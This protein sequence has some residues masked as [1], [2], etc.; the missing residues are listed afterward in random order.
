M[1]KI[2]VLAT[3]GLKPEQL[4]DND[5]KLYPRVDYLELKRFLDIDILNYSLY[6]QTW[7]G[8]SFRSLETQI[9]SDLY[10]TW[11]GWRARKNYDL[12]FTMSERA[13]IP[14]AGFRRLG[15]NS[16]PFVTMFQS[17]SWRQESVIK[18][19]GLLG[20]MDGIAVHCHSMKC[21][22][23]DLGAPL[24]DIQVLPYS[25]DHQF[26]KPMKGVE[27]QQGLIMSV[28]EIRS[29]D[30]GTLMKAV[31]KLPLRLVIAASGSWYAREKTTSLRLPIPDNTTITGRM[32]SFKLRE[33]YAQAQFVVLPVYNTVYSAGSTVV[34]EAS[35]MERAV[36]A[37]RSEGIVDYIIDGETGILVEPNNP[38]ALR[39]AIRYLQDHPG[40]AKRMGR[41]ARQRVEESFNLD[42]YVECMAQQ[43]QRYLP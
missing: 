17:W 14:F 31:K 26:F 9:H 16:Q 5:N 2:L 39:E 18:N 36:I 13:G 6:N 29:R 22:L 23:N 42:H 19:F 7:L 15:A 27:Q 12:V 40:E 35:S 38:E 20:K 33:L 24:E 11:L 30:Y 10:L 28:G 1:S 32:S 41:N 34:M 21:H 25:V 43:L 3:A 37:T 8:E 4:E